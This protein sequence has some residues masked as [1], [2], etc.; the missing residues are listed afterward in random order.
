MQFFGL[1][2]QIKYISKS[3]LINNQ[4]TSKFI[5]I[6]ISINESIYLNIIFD[7]VTAENTAIAEWESI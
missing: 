4:W 5:C 7:S 2:D 1:Y 6:K 3:M